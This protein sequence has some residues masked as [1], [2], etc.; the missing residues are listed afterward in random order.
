MNQVPLYVTFGL[1]LTVFSYGVFRIK[2]FSDDL[3]RISSENPLNN[4]ARNRQY[5]EQFRQN[6]VL[7]KYSNILS[8][9][10]ALPDVIILKDKERRF[11]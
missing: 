11:S 5:L 9:R 4:L 6:E 3:K 10:N 2:Q 1:V 7:N 8:S